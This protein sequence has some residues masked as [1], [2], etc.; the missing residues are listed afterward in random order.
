MLV[1]LYATNRIIANMGEPLRDD[2][3][4]MDDDAAA[5]N[6]ETTI[7]LAPDPEHGITEVCCDPSAV[8]D[9]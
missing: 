3:E 9:L 4:D 6:P 7:N 2:N 8:V 1:G 5:Y